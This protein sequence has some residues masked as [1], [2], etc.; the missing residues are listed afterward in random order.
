LSKLGNRSGTDYLSV[1]AAVRAYEARPIEWPP[2][3]WAVLSNTT[4][5][6]FEPFLKRLCYDAGFQA[7]IAVGGYDTVLQDALDPSSAVFAGRPSVVVVA[8]RLHGLAPALVERFATLSDADVA[9]EA[10]RALD[11]VTQICKAVRRR[12]QALLL[13]HTFETPLD[14]EIGALDYR[15]TSGQVNTVRR[16]NLALADAVSQ[17]D[18]A[19]LVDLDAVRASVGAAA[20]VDA[21]TWHIGRVP[22]S[23]DGMAAIA[24][25]YM[26]FV[27]ALKGLNKKCL[28]VDADGTLWGG[29]VGEDGV[30]GIEIGRSFPGSGFR[31]FQQWLLSLRARGILLALCS[32]NDEVLVREVFAARAE[33]MPLRLDHF[34]A[35]RVNW[36]DKAQNILEI[37][38]EL[39]IGLDSL[40]FVDDSAFEVDLVRELLP[41]VTTIQLPPDPVHFR[42]RLAS[43]GLFDTLTVSDEDRRRG[44]MYAAERERREELAAAGASLDDYLSGLAMEV[45]VA[46]VDDA[47]AARVAQLTQKTN[48]FNLTTRRYSEADIQ[49]LRRSPAHDVISVRLRDRFGDS[50]IVGVA[51]LRHG[52]GH[53][54]I[55]TL[56]LSCRVLERGVEDVLLAVCLR[57]SAERGSVDIIGQFALSA[58]NSRVA[59][60]YPSRGFARDEDGAWR[61][62]LEGAAAAPFPSHIRAVVVDGRPVL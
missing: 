59:G 49:A 27:R 62:S 9:V 43:S 35:V 3:A 15:S 42:D 34:A 25:E 48:Q 40:V 17:I 61:R 20:F 21:R 31:D 36:T 32:K 24:N 1:L 60:F 23:R 6:P 16:L 56:L 10:A 47:T 14:P 44:E 11:Y 12:S 2:I 37:A 13:V 53:S 39:N 4:V 38:G 57:L 19:F 30:H 51:I 58:R 50:G 33:D 22:Y 52:R 7:R 5:E 54:V 18:G 55:E 41:P 8:L 45:H 46:A 26:K 28:V 29:I